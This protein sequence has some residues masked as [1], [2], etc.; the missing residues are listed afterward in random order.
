MP[1]GYPEFAGAALGDLGMALSSAASILS[2]AA[3]RPLPHFRQ[4]AATIPAT[5]RASLKPRQGRCIPAQGGAKRSPGSAPPPDGSPIGATHG[6]NGW[7][8]H[9]ARRWE[10]CRPFRAPVIFS[11]PDPGLAPR[12]PVSHLR[13]CVQVRDRR[14]ALHN[15]RRDAAA[16]LVSCVSWLPF[17]HRSR[18]GPSVGHPTG[19]GE[20]PRCRDGSGYGRVRDRRQALHNQRRDAAATL[21]RA[22]RAFRGDLRRVTPPRNPLP[23]A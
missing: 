18:R 6:D 14:Q 13:C 11:C 23:S 22:V 1:D 20:R 17:C 9:V 19:M 21:F 8:D 4:H 10:M 12:A 15:Q 7:N 5:C 16:T 2:I 3:R